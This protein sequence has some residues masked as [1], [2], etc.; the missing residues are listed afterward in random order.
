MRSEDEPAVLALLHDS[1]AGGP[2]GERSAD[3]FHW[4]HHRNPFGR[5]PALV[6]T[7]GERVVGLRTFLRWEFAVGQS[8]V[9]AVRAVD[10]ATAESHRGR[11][12]FRTLTLDLLEDVRS[13]CAFVFNTPNA[14]S[15]PGYL[16]MG[17]ERVGEV[18]IHVGP[19]RPV[20]FLRGIRSAGDV[21]SATDEDRRA[22]RLPSAGE[23]LSELPGLESLLDDIAAADAA[24]GALHTRRTPAYLQWRYVEPPGLDYRAVTVH[25]HGRLAG[26]AIGR[27]RRRGT[28]RE[29]TLS[30]VLVRPRD[31]SGARRVLAAA[32]RS[33]M[34]HVAGHF[35]EGTAAR[36]VATSRG[37]FRAPHGMTL[38][39]KFLS[40]GPA[41]PLRMGNWRLSVGD[42]EVF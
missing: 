32:R 17:W 8:T 27:P 16:K 22:C 41:D 1:L 30:E 6:A 7:S 42:L 28:L 38:T 36:S 13:E 33:G 9:R 21:V 5:S 26:L 29:L 10:T 39:A 25:E 23:V 34:D 35:A 37:F 12:L 31:R 24:S 18:P 40:D 4:K 3:F 15:L 2:T 14:N 20:R 11:G 19:A